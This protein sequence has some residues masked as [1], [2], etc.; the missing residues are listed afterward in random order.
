MVFILMEARNKM[1]PF[2]SERQREKFIE[3]NEGLVYFV[4]QHLPEWI[5]RIHPTEDILQ[6]GRIGL[7]KAVD[8]FN[9]NKKTKFSSYATTV[10]HNQIRSKLSNLAPHISPYIN[11]Y[12]HS[13]PVKDEH[14]KQA[15]KVLSAFSSDNFIR[16][17]DINEDGIDPIDTIGY[18]NIPEATDPYDYQDYLSN[19]LL[20]AWL[21]KN[22]GNLGELYWRNLNGETFRELGKERGVSAQYINQLV[23]ELKK[24]IKEDISKLRKA[25]IL[26]PDFV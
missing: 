4:Y 5:K 14:K 11:Y 17:N 22:Y 9:P 3:A 12:C 25:H 16:W 23:Q 24:Q 19:Q 6:E 7:V 20:K 8:S 1:S 26:N 21:K 2:V 10:I 15:R 18:A 13:K